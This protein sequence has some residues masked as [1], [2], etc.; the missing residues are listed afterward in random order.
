MLQVGGE[1]ISR[2]NRSAPHGRELGVQHLDRDPPAVAQVAREVD[3]RHAAAADLAL[4]AVA[5]DEG[6]LQTAYELG[7]ALLLSSPLL[8]D[9]GI[10]PEGT[11]WREASAT[12]GWHLSCRCSGRLHSDPPGTLSD[13]LIEWS[14]LESRGRGTCPPFHAG[15]LEWGIW[16][17]YLP[18]ATPSRGTEAHAA[19]QQH[20]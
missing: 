3:R 6:G 13:C 10:R 8:V 11:R 16:D 9:G 20:G 7:N 1:L 15:K 12:S 4:E 17:L 19:V 14:A 18:G 5:V 2:R